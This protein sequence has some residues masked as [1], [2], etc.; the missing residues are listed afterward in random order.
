MSGCSTVRDV[1]GSPARVQMKLGVFGMPASGAEGR[2]SVARV[3]L[4]CK[5][6][7]RES[8]TRA[9]EVRSP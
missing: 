3:R 1:L 5:G 6:C 9:D 7:F 2:D 4:Y 8:C